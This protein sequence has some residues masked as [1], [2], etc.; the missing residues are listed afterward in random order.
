MD[1]TFSSSVILLGITGPEGRYMRIGG[2]RDYGLSVMDLIRNTSR[3]LNGVLALF[4]MYCSCCTGGYSTE[5]AY[6]R[7][8]VYKTTQCGGTTPPRDVVS[9][10]AHLLN[11]DGAMRAAGYIYAIIL[12]RR[13]GRNRASESGK[14]DIT[15]SGM[16]YKR[17]DTEMK[18]H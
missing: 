13:G 9:K 7:I 10:T 18:K 5:H 4:S 17:T 3:C 11:S 16:P 14:L 2:R 8:E 6:K 1:I 15:R 12:C